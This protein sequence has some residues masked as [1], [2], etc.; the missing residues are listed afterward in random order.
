MHDQFMPTYIIV[1]PIITVFAISFF[2]LGHY[3]EHVLHAENIAAMMKFGMITAFAF[4]VWYFWFGLVMLKDYWK[5]YFR[6]HFHVSQW[7]LICPFVG[8]SVLGGFVF[9]LFAPY[10]VFF[11]F[12]IFI[13]A[14]VSLMYLYLLKRQT[15]C[16]KGCEKKNFVCD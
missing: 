7:G 4:Q 16:L 15:Q 1:I 5:T 14:L 11:Y 12:L 10:M 8:F 3:S 2:R 9:N 6:S 13:L